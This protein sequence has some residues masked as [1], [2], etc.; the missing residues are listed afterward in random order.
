MTDYL[1]CL[2]CGWFKVFQTGD[3][4]GLCPRCCLCVTELRRGRIVLREEP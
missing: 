1:Y 2:L 4:N 3:T